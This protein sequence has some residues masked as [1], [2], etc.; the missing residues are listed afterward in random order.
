[1]TV[2]VARPIGGSPNIDLEFVVC[3]F[4]QSSLKNEVESESAT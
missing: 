3:K 4:W 2:A 1:M